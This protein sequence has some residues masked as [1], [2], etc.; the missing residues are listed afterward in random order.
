MRLS[1]SLYAHYSQLRRGVR[2]IAYVMFAAGTGGI[3]VCIVMMS[4]PVP[5]R[6]DGMVCSLACLKWIAGYTVTEESKMVGGIHGTV[7]WYTESY[8]PCSIMGLSLQH[9]CM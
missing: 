6:E 4:A 9:L 7:R 3:V 5:G 2:L 1:G 8:L